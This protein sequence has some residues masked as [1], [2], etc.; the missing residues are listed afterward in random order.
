MSKYRPQIPMEAK[1]QANPIY[2]IPPKGRPRSPR[3]HYRGQKYLL[4]SELCNK[5]SSEIVKEFSEKLAKTNSVSYD[6]FVE[7]SDAANAIV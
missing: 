7:F 6:Q 3:L 2:I 1:I 5:V 4:D